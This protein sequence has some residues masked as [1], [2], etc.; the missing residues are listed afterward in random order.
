VLEMSI[1]V[2]ITKLLNI[3]IETVV[4]TLQ[5]VHRE[6]APEI[7]FRPELGLPRNQPSDLLFKSLE[8][9]VDTGYFRSVDLYDDESA[10]P[11]E[12]FTKIYRFAKSRGLKCKAH[13]GEFTDA[14]FVKKSVEILELDIVQHGIAAADSVEVMKWLAKHAIQ[15]NVC[16]ASNIALK[17]TK[18]YK[19]HPIRILYDNG[20]KVTVN[21]DDILLFGKGNSEQYLQLYKSG[22]L[23]AEELD[24]IRLNGLS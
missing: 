10:Q 8:P 2:L 24:V 22:L 21:T 6:I 20:V 11:L 18:S 3:P 14:D 7:I 4:S 12:N 19:T 17:R 16:P 5:Q 15:V 13:A 23:K 9:F 1:D